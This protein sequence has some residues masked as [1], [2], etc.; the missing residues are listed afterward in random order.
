MILQKVLKKVL[1]WLILSSILVTN[2]SAFSEVQNQKAD[3]SCGAPCIEEA[4]GI[5]ILSLR[6]S[7]NGYMLDF[8]YRLIDPKKAASL[9]DI[10]NKPYLIDQASGV[11]CYVPN[12]PKVGSLRTTKNPE[13]NKNY[14]ILFAN[15]GKFIKAGNK[16]TV[17]VGDFRAE[18]LTVE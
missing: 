17:V 3:S 8:R 2:Y 11:K 6:L 1:S 7:A 18:N 15:P 5:K 14:F 16:V 12:P 4:W 13:P 9:F 10:R